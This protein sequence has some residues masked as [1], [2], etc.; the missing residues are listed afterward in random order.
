MAERGVEVATT[1]VGD[2]YVL[3]ELREPRLGARRRAVRATSSTCG[4]APSGD[5]IAAAL[6]TLE[7]LARRAT[8]PT[9]TRWR[10]CPSAR[11]RARRRP[12]AALASATSVQRRVAARVRRARGPRARAR[13][14]ERHRAARARDGRGAEGRGGRRGL[15]A[16]RR[17]RAAALRR[18]DR[19][20]ASPRP[21]TFAT[22]ARVCIGGDCRMPSRGSPEAGRRSSR[23]PAQARAAYLV[24]KAWRGP[25]SACDGL[26][27]DT[28]CGSAPGGVPTDASVRSRSAAPVRP[29]SCRR[30]LD[31]T[32][33]RR[34]RE[35]AGAEISAHGR[36]PTPA[37][38]RRGCRG[39]RSPQFCSALGAPPRRRGRTDAQLARPA[40]PAGG[41]RGAPSRPIS[42]R[43]AR[44]GCW[45]VQP[46]ARW[47]ARR[48]GRGRACS[49][50]L[51]GPT[52]AAAGRGTAPAA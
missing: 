18:A 23:H 8:S 45:D 34:L 10:S 9:A 46:P 40:S 39:I 41:R 20:R 7:A 11:Q 1:R 43:H 5:G 13:A 47:A 21:W 42:D 33:S 16:A 28:R 31:P 14:P 24:V 25:R 50:L 52:A 35:R 27:H 49:R 17:R 2:R 37:T 15:R 4:F 32:A 6:L 22:V 12:R 3:E 36:R 38:S 26:D 30:G 29:R 44:R 19:A 51:R 48:R